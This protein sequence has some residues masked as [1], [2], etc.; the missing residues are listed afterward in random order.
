VYIERQ[1]HDTVP[2]PLSAESGIVYEP[3]QALS[4]LIRAP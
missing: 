1:L 4:V 2:L 3:D